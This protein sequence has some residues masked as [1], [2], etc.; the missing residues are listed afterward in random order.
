M[1]ILIRLSAYQT[2]KDAQYLNDYEAAVR[3]VMKVLRTGNEIKEDFS[4]CHGLSGICELLITGWEMFGDNSNK[5]IA[6]DSGMKEI[7]KYRNQIWPCGISNGETPNL[8]L[9]LAGIGYHY[10]R[11]YDK[12]KVP[13]ILVIMAD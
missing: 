2:L 11:L 12:L 13:S 5:S 1:E 4:L 10:L 8:L 7:E 6:I 3:N 9:G